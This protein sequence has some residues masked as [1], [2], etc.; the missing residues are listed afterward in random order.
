[1]DVT[2]LDIAV[3]K[4][5]G[6]YIRCVIKEAELRRENPDSDTLPFVSQTADRAHNRI[7]HLLSEQEKL[8]KGNHEICNPDTADSTN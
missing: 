8:R 3:T 4:A 7:Q 2:D 1:M 5:L 6:E